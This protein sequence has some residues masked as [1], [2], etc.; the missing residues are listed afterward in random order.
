MTYSWPEN[1]LIIAEV[2]S[3]HNG[4]LDTARRL[5]AT[6]ADCGADV[7][8]FQGFLADELLAAN[9]PY[10][11]RMKALEV[12]RAWYPELI[13]ACERSNVRF[14]STATNFTTLE[15]MEQEGAWGYKVASCNIT[16]R[17]MLDR[18]ADIG[19]PV[20]ISTGMAT[21]DEIL[22]TERHLRGKGLDSLAFLHCIA[23]YP[24]PARQMNLGNI[25]ALKAALS[26]PVG[27]SDHSH[28]THIPVAAVAL[29][30]VIVEKHISLDKSGIGLDHEVAVLPDVFAAMCREIRDVEVALRTDFSVDAETVKNM[31]RSLHFAEAFEAGHVISESDLKVTRPEDGLLAEHASDVIGRR[32]ARPVRQKEAVQWEHLE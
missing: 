27:L 23:Q 16:Y 24:A 26:G 20:I 6:A 9:D 1:T 4:D 7:V 11:E 21:Y 8:K 31:R 3:N 29:G 25:P 5:I 14:L 13:A 15:W 30:A 32:L 10:Y 22:A 28:G 17:P 12:P 2:G 18:L 19:K